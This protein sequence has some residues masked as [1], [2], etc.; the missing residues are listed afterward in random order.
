MNT[1]PSSTM[2]IYYEE[3]YASN[4][5]HTCIPAIVSVF[6]PSFRS[7]QVNKILQLGPKSSETPEK[8]ASLVHRPSL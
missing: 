2:L 8:Q 5:P 6:L 7:A 3:I 1:G 4:S